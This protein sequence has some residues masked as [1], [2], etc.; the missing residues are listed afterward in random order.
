MYNS[1]EEIIFSMKKGSPTLKSVTTTINRYVKQRNF[2][3]AV[4]FF[5]AKIKYKAIIED[6]EIYKCSEDDDRENI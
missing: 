2:K 6:G 5:E 1:V 3:K 4:M